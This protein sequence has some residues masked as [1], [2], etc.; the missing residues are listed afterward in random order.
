MERAKGFRS[1]RGEG[2]CDGAKRG[3]RHGPV[4]DENFEIRA[5][6]YDA[7]KGVLKGLGGSSTGGICIETSEVDS[8]GPPA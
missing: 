7:D 2:V 4:N 3:G 5:V 6:A 8:P 1:K